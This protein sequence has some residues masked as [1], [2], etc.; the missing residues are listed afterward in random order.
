[1]LEKQCGSLDVWVILS[2]LNR[3]GN[4]TTLMSLC[5]VP[6]LSI[7]NSEVV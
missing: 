5:N 6:K 4:A 7:K 1:M 3:F 2:R